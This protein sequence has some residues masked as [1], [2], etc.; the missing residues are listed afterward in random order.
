M[1]ASIIQ[2]DALNPA[3]RQFLPKTAGSRRQPVNPAATSATA[4]TVISVTD[5]RARINAKNRAY[6]LF[7]GI[8]AMLF[9]FFICVAMVATGGWV[10]Y[11]LFAEASSWSSTDLIDV[12]KN[13]NL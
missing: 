5:E 12:L 7:T 2:P 4:E 9:V 11:E 1:S 8:V 13:S 10:V 6:D 3:H